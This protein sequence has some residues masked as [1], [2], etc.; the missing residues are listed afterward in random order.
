MMPFADFIIGKIEDMAP[1]LP[2]RSRSILLIT[3]IE[4][5][6]GPQINLGEATVALGNLSGISLNDGEYVGIYF[7]AIKNVTVNALPASMNGKFAV[8]YS[9]NGKSWTLFAPDGSALDMAY[10]RLRNYTGEVQAF[11]VDEFEVSVSSASGSVVEVTTNM[12]ASTE[13]PI[14]NVIDGK[15]NTYFWKNGSQSVGDYITL[16]YGSSVP[17]FDVTL[18]FTSND[19]PSGAGVVELSDNGQ[20]W[21]AI[22]SFTASQITGNG[23]IFSCNAGGKSGRYVR[24]RLTSVSSTYWLQVAEF[25]ASTSGSTPGSERSGR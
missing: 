24:M 22:A 23:N 14:T 19:S 17:V 25:E 5:L 20:N 16:D 15:T 21:T 8:E 3:N 12:R 13:Y 2:E 6:T 7:N 1:R 11:P 4:N 9:I 10:I 18:T